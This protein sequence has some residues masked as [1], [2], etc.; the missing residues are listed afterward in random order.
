MTSPRHHPRRDIPRSVF[1][2]FPACRPRTF[3]YTQGMREVGHSG[4]PTCRWWGREALVE[5]FANRAGL[6]GVLPAVPAKRCPSLGDGFA[7]TM[8]RSTTTFRRATVTK[9]RC[10]RVVHRLAVTAKRRARLL[11]RFFAT[12]K[13][14]PTLVHRPAA[15]SARSLRLLHPFAATAFLP[16]NL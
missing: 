7:V 2:C 5:G 1:S 13:R 11:H 10:T 9:K 12:A 14:H 16:R 15:A 6:G 8:K 3:A 4:S